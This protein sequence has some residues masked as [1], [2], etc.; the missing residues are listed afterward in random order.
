MKLGLDDKGGEGFPGEENCLASPLEKCKHALLKGTCAPSCQKL[1]TAQSWVLREGI[2]CNLLCSQA[3]KPPC[4][5]LLGGGLA[6][7]LVSRQVD[8]EG[9][10]QPANRR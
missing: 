3:R 4:G 7:A 5:M 8:E 1:A 2:N 6:G 10:N 9:L